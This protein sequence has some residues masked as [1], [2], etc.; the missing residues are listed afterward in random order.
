MIT[1]E[2]ELF[3]ASSTEFDEF[4]RNDEV[5][6]ALDAC[7]ID[8]EREKDLLFDVFSGTWTIAGRPVMPITPAVWSVLW[9]MRSPFTRKNASFRLLD[10]AV[11]LYLLSHGVDRLDFSTLEESAMREGASWG[12]PEDVE[13]IRDELLELVEVANA[14]LKMLP[15]QMSRV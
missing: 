9:V 1:T 14:P 15:Q 5:L 13:A 3:L 4:L 10:I 2:Q 8:Y 11:F 6:K 12:L 7:R